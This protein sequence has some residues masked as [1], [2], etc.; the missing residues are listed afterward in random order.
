MGARPRPNAYCELTSAD[1]DAIAAGQAIRDDDMGSAQQEGILPLHNAP[2]AHVT[3][4]LQAI[5]REV[6]ENLEAT[7]G[8]CLREVWNALLPTTVENH[9]QTPRPA[10]TSTVRRAQATQSRQAKSQLENPLVGRAFVTNRRNHGARVQDVSYVEEQSENRVSNV[11]S[12]PL[13]APTHVG[14][15]G[16]QTGLVPQTGETRTLVNVDP[17][18]EARIAEI[19]A[20]GNRVVPA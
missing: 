16:M 3:S 4:D 7:I 8:P 9:K 1:L 17:I 18:E 13:P 19:H 11:E 15:A 2:A 12:Q 20:T 10:L 5:A 14:S 6:L